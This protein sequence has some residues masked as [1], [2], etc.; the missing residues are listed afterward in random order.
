MN[1]RAMKSQ[2][3]EA[4]SKMAKANLG[5]KKILSEKSAIYHEICHNKVPQNG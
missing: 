3:M 1:V 2:K 4:D 5:E